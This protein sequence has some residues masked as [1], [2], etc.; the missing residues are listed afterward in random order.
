MKTAKEIQENLSSFTV[1]EHYFKNPFGIM[2]TD[3][4]H[5]LATACECYWMI[6]IIASYQFDDKVK[7]ESFQVFHL[8]VHSDK[9]AIITISD[10]NKNILATQELDYTS[11][12]LDEIEIWCIDRIALLP[13]EY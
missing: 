7:A 3:G 6:D 4:I 8:K 13:S 11:F 9:S 10:G 1:T 12:P 5:Y 2:Y